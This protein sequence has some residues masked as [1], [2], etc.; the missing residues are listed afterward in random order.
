MSTL[1][2]VNKSPFSD[3]SLHSC[4]NICSSGDSVLLIEDGTY[5]ALGSAPTF[6]L[7]QRAIERDIK[8]YALESDLM[9]RGLQS[10]IA[11]G[12]AIANYPAFVELSCQ[13]TTVQSWY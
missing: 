11:Q 12:I 10:Q 2:T 4:L 1:H 9:A 7:L 13:H 5:G 3:Q 8:V 6:K